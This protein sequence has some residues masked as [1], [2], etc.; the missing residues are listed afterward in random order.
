MMRSFLV[1]AVAVLGMAVILASGGGDDGPFDDGV[2]NIEYRVFGSAKRATI[3]YHTGNA[4]ETIE[5]NLP[6]KIL[7]KGELPFEAILNVVNKEI[8]N[9]GNI[10]LQLFVDGKL[11]KQSLAQGP[12]TFVIQ[13]YALVE[14]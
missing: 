9:G 7:F 6:W 8:F 13:L 5:A 1:L 10:N 11:F 2:R 12:H 3:I 14:D 4:I